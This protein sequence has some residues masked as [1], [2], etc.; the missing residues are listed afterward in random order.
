[1]AESKQLSESEIARETLRLL[2]TRKLQ[3]TPDN[4][5]S[6]YFE[7]AGVAPAVAFPERELKALQAGLPRA[8]ADQLKFARQ[9]EAAIAKGSWDGI[10]ATITEFL[11]K[12]GEQP[13]WS[14]IIRDMLTQLETHHSGLTAAKKKDALDQVLSGAGTPDVLVTRLQALIRSWSQQAPAERSSMASSEPL[15]LSAAPAAASAAPAAAASSLPAVAAPWQG[16]VLDLRDIIAQ[17]LDN[18]LSIVL[19]DSPDLASEATAISAAVRAAKNGDAL[20]GLSERLKKLCYRALFVAEDQSEMGSALLHL[21]QLIIDNISELVVEDKWLTGQIKVVRDLIQQP[22][23]L[24][25]LDD[26]ERRMKDVIVKQSAL[27]K[28]LN[29]ANERLKLMLATFVDR[30]GDFSETTSD[31]HNKIE[32]Y[33]DK[34]S[35]AGDITELTDVL[36]EV[37]R[38]TRVVQVNAARSRDEMGSMRVRVTEAEEVV[39]RLQNELSNASE[40]VRHDLLTGA[41]N[42]KGLDEALEKE[43]GRLRRQ[44]GTLSLALLDID[45]FKKLNEIHGNVVGDAALVHL[46]KIVQTTVRPQDQL[47]RYGG[48][49]FVVLLP[50][51]PIDDAVAVMTRVQR[52]LTREFFLT[53]NEKVL[54]TFSCGVAEIHDAE[55]PYEALKRAD[56]GMYRAKRAGKNRVIPA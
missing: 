43:I 1:M 50:N 10:S 13:Q 44:K 12:S 7:I 18:T 39:A 46:S 4:Y 30:L 54:I 36:D 2:A 3:P 41:L 33:A 21:V 40:L 17:L 5:R 29:E 48:E 32:G 47:A 24:R 53:N 51:T 56:A 28:S 35:K 26:V 11:A 14:N 34:I 15:P 27:K 9:F 25:R 22:L 49:E 42:R 38:E 45:N 6:L 8:S 55:D 37:M 16:G 52:E 31:Y 23:S 20:V 19:R